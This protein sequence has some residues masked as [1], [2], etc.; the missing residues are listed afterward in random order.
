MPRMALKVLVAGGGVA[1]L[2]TVI[3]LRELAGDRVVTLLLAP[4]RE[5]VY[6]P[7][8]TGD[9]FALGAPRTFPLEELVERVGSS[10]LREGLVSVDS[11]RHTVRTS[12][13]RTLDYDALVIA[14]GAVQVPAFEH[15]LTFTGP[16]SAEA[17]HG[18][19]QDLEA[20][21]VHRIAFVVPE[22][23]TWPLPLYELALQSA[24]RAYETGASV[25][26]SLVTPE[27]SPLE[28]FGPEA[29]RAVGE[30]LE[31]AGVRFTPG[32]SATVPQRGRVRLGDSDQWIE[33]DRVVAAP[34][35]RGPR[36]DGLP[37]DR[38]GFVP[39]D[40][41]GRV[42]GVPRVYAAGDVTSFPVKQGGIATQQAD[43]A[44]EVIAAE[45]GAE[46][47]PQPFHPIL[48][49]MLLTG[50]QPRY[51]R[52]DTEHAD[53]RVAERTLFWPPG[54]IAGRFLSP[55]LGEEPPER[56]DDGMPLDV[57]LHAHGA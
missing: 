47:D 16:G 38:D 5:F 7:L 49:G 40:E 44:L 25:E 23:I 18:V 48:R 24:E 57:D 33:A 3:G 26:V 13:R 17:M 15:V 45:A 37:A 53:G 28:A 2:E 19:V 54:K 20:G 8:S 11:R 6:R 1:A 50:R 46:V 29:G 34:L 10:H 35:L 27:R 43:A 12:G 4:D 51:I 9:P 32:V 56:P 42:I 39:T 31:G 22:G 55:F 14:L 21:Y 52:Y 36:I 30:L 41:H